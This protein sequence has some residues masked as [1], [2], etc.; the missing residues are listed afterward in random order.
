M[1]TTYNDKIF[2]NLFLG[3]IRIHILY[4]ASK[5]PVFGL[6]MLKELARHG[7]RMSSSTLYPMLHQMEL[8][9]LLS[10][11]KEV[12]NGKYHKYY[13]ITEE[14]SQALLQAYQKIKELTRELNE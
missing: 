2:R 9:G 10:S 11:G 13:R 7:Y 3:F 8:S 5:Q 14:G 1:T 12:T 4:H 6:D